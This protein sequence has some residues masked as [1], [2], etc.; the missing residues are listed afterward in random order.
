MMHVPHFEH[1]HQ[2]PPPS[3][4]SCAYHRRLPGNGNIQIPAA[5]HCRASQGPLLNNTIG[6]ENRQNSAARPEPDAMPPP[7][8]ALSLLSKAGSKEFVRN[9]VQRF[10]WQAAKRQEPRWSGVDS[11]A[12]LACS[13]RVSRHARPHTM[14]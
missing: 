11:T 12:P 5:R 8:A 7:L 13:L 2:L 3:P 4:V 10:V 14:E 9:L 1:P 6:G